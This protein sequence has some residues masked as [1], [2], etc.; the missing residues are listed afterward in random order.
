MHKLRIKR[1]KA[2]I[3]KI[4][5]IWIVRYKAFYILFINLPFNFLFCGRNENNN[6]KNKTKQKQQQLWNVNLWGQKV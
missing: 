1:Y 6:N 4:Y 2:A 5:K 3:I